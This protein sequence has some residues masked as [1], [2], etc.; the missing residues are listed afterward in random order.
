MLTLFRYCL[1]GVFAALFFV[2]SPHAYAAQGGPPL[3]DEEAKRI[4]ALPFLKHKKSIVVDRILPAEDGGG[5]RLARYY[6]QDGKSS[7]EGGLYAAWG[8]YGDAVLHEVD[9][10]GDDIPDLVIAHHRKKNG[11]T[12]FTFY[13]GCGNGLLYA[14]GS[15]G[16]LQGGGFSLEGDTIADN[17]THW[18]DIVLIQDADPDL[19]ARHL[20]AMTQTEHMEVHQ[21]VWDEAL[22]LAAMPWVPGPS[23]NA[24]YIPGDT[25]EGAPVKA[26]FGEFRM[27]V[28]GLS[29]PLRKSEGNDS[30]IPSFRRL[31]LNGD[32]APDIQLTDGSGI[33]HLYAGCGNGWYTEVFDDLKPEDSLGEPILKQNGFTWKTILRPRP[34]LGTAGIIVFVDK[35]YVNVLP[36]DVA[37]RLAKPVPKWAKG[38]PL[39]VRYGDETYVFA[40]DTARTLEYFPLNGP[41]GYEQTLT[42]FPY[43]RYSSETYSG[44]SPLKLNS[45]KHQDYFATIQGSYG[46]CG[47]SMHTFLAGVGH[48]RFVSVGSAYIDDDSIRTNMKW[49]KESGGLRWYTITGTERA[50]MRAVPV[51]YPFRPEKKNYFDY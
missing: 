6:L 25:G 26:Y 4:L 28:A 1:Y 14:L 21:Y 9:L 23:F 34:D 16:E 8:G 46:S 51:S 10:N 27:N 32:A 47:S 43:D 37:D 17:G 40:K 39:V 41:R 29:S 31:D 11:L 50:G 24:L 22:R 7:D 45:D 12:R 30:L 33:R 2:F 20:F 13:A 5:V 48:N 38:R 19:P 49:H 42:Y 3:P 15:S 36:R 44:F 18:K 35:A